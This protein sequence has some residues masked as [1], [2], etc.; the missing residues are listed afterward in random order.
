MC[1]GLRMLPGLSRSALHAGLHRRERELVLEVDVGDDRHRRA[2]HD[3]REA[4]GRRLLV[5]GA[6]HDVAPRRGERVDLRERA[7]DVG[8]L[9]GG[10]RLH[11]HRR[12]ATDRD[13][14]DVDLPCV[15]ARVVRR[16]VDSHC[17]VRLASTASAC[18]GAIATGR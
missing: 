14:A 12:V 18:P 15:A 10:H 11:R 1:S 5:A 4:L 6:A 17:A 9:G 7:V 16:T 3:L 13:V 2:R 8:G